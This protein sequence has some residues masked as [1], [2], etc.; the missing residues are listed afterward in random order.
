MNAE[1]EKLEKNQIRLWELFELTSD[2]PDVISEIRE[3]LQEIS[4]TYTDLMAMDELGESSYRFLTFC[5]HYIEVDKNKT[6]LN[7]E[8]EIGEVWSNVV[9]NDNFPA[10]IEEDLLTAIKEEKVSNVFPVQ[11]MANEFAAQKN[12][13][14]ALS[15]FQVVKN[16]INSPTAWDNWARCCAAQDDYATAIEVLENGLNDYPDSQILAC[17]RAFY[18]HKNK[19]N[20]DAL[21]ALQAFIDRVEVAKYVDDN[22]Y[23]YAVKLKAS[24]YRELNMPLQALIEYCRLTTAG[25]CDQEFA[26]N[27]GE[28]MVPY[29]EALNYG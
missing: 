22:F 1:P 14:K 2:A 29:V 16:H 3:L 5:L 7:L 23:I 10:L 28:S 20:N 26:K 6:Y 13:P 8:Y 11:K 24:I 9:N 19:K 4:S 15:Y 17:N 12:Y 27:N 18:L 21:N 25:Q